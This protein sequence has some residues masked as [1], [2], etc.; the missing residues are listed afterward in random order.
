MSTGAA[1]VNAPAPPIVAP[2]PAPVKKWTENPNQGNFNPGTKLGSDTFKLKTKCL[3]DDKRL[4][5]DKKDAQIFKRLLEAKSP[6]FGQVV[7]H[8]PILFAPDGTAT[9]HGNLLANYSKISIE[10]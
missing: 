1:A 2:A 4:A 10:L 7:T 5:L 6:T 8:I 9:Q 3:S